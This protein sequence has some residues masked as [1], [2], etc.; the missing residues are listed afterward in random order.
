ME[1]GFALKVETI[2]CV[3]VRNLFAVVVVVPDIA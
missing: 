1:K 2:A 3:M